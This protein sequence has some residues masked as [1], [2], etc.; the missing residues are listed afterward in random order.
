MTK[1]SKSTLIFKGK[2]Y[3]SP[4]YSAFMKED[5]S[6]PQPDTTLRDLKDAFKHY[7]STGYHPSLGKDAAYARP[8]E[9]LRLS[10]RHTHTDQGIYREDKEYSS[11]KECWDAWKAG[12]GNTKPS[13][14][15]CLIYVVNN[16]RDA[17][18]TAFVDDDAHTIT[19]RASYM[20]KIMQRAY[21]FFEKTASQAMP[22]EQHL[23][24]FDERWS[25]ASS[26]DENV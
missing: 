12:Y 26:D 21:W 20:D 7:W 2:V 23:F 19:E 25:I 22:L 8:G 17:M 1:E 10:V 11:T 16:Q 13:S 6:L 5:L 24:L 3:L 18:L 9:I 15:A 4:E 14:N